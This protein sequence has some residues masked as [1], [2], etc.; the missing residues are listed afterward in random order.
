MRQSLHNYFLIL[1]AIFSFLNIAA[2]AFSQTTA[3]VPQTTYEPMP[4][5]PMVFLPTESVAGA[6]PQKE[7]VLRRLDINKIGTEASYEQFEGLRLA[8]YIT[9]AQRVEI[10]QEPRSIDAYIMDAKAMR[11]L[12]GDPNNIVRRLRWVQTWDTPAHFRQQIV[13]L[14]TRAYGTEFTMSMPTGGPDDPGGFAQI[15]YTL[16]YRDIF[17]QY[18]P[19]YAYYSDHFKVENWDTND[20]MLIHAKKIEPLGWLYT[21][22]YG[23]KY[24]TRIAKNCDNYYNVMHSY[25]TNQSMVVNDRLEI[26]GQAQYQKEIHYKTA[27]DFRPDHYWYAGELRIKSDDLKTSFIPRLSYSLD[28][29]FPTYSR[30]QKWEMEFRV[31]RD[32]TERFRAST[33]VKYQ[34]SIRNDVD[35]TAPTY[36]APNP[37]NDFGAWLGCENRAQYLVYDKLWLQSGFD[38]SAGMNMSDFDNLGML[39]GIEYYAPGLIRVDFGWRGNHYYNINDYLSCLYFKVYLFM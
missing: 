30:Y 24:T 32:F 36:A 31:G 1:I 39:W 12:Y 2:P 10:Y 20:V 6:A 21:A 38:Y 9:V 14:F 15:R 16:D 3:V 13:P 35:N 28:K 7:Y 8:K 34:M 19:K 25:Y 23:Y 37:I 11:Y 18:F 4:R 33:A 27:Y 22:N 29:Y 17:N 5:R 26:F